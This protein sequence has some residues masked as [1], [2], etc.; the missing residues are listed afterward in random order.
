MVEI[1]T[2]FKLFV[3]IYEY[4]RIGKRDLNR[5]QWGIKI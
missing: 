5:G 2:A 3:K 1:I 4:Y